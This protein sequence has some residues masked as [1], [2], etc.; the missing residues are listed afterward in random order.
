MVLS[1]K[2]PLEEDAPGWVDRLRDDGAMIMP[3]PP[4]GTW[5]VLMPDGRAP[6]TTCP[7]CRKLF[8]SAVAAQRVAN[9]TYPMAS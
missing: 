3:R 4:G 5:I 2:I 6:L 9:H 1:G 8:R 7:C